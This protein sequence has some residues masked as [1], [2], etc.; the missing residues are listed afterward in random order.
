MVVIRMVLHSGNETVVVVDQGVLERV[1]N[2]TDQVVDLGSG[3]TELLLEGAAHL[4]EDL[5]RE[6][7]LVEISLRCPEK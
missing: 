1:E 6:P 3:S 2:L 5:A 4:I 7:Y